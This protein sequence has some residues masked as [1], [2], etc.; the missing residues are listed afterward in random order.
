MLEDIFGCYHRG[1]PVGSGQSYVQ[2]PTMTT[3]VSGLRITGSENT[4]SPGGRASP[5]LQ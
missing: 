4:Q 5:E 2:C 3:K 1:H